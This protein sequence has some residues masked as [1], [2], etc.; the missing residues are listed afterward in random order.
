MEPAHVFYKELPLDENNIF[1]ANLAE[2]H[3]STSLS[4]KKLSSKNLRN[5]QLQVYQLTKKLN[6][7]LSS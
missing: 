2:N 1:S 7:I 5:M 3:E 4:S 6:Q